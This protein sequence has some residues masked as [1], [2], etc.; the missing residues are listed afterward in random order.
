MIVQNPI[1]SFKWWYQFWGRVP[2][3]QNSGL[4]RFCTSELNSVVYTLFWYNLHETCSL[5]EKMGEKII[6][7]IIKL[8]NV[9][10]K[11]M[12]QISLNKKISTIL[13]QCV[14]KIVFLHNY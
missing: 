9:L 5:V 11:Y 8:T 7:F 12:Y 10:K 6:F 2:W 4:K 14:T 13:T 3:T 1:L